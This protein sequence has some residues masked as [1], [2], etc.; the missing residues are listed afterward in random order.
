MNE[1]SDPSLDR[2][3]Y[4]VVPDVVDGES[5][6]EFD[7]QVSSVL[8][9]RAGARN[10]LSHDWCRHLALRLARHPAIADV[11]ASDAVAIS[12]TLFDKRAERN[13]S[14]GVHQDL[15]V[16]VARREDVPG[17]KGWTRKQGALFVQPPEDLLGRLLA[18]RVHLDECTADNGPLRVVP[19]THRLGRITEEDAL[20]L[21]DEIGEA[22]CVV[23]A[24]GALLMRPLLLHASGKAVSGRPRRVLHFVYGPPS[25]H[26][27]LSWPEDATS[28]AAFAEQSAALAD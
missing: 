13:W 2:S 9:Q 1:P 25:P 27:S 11:L 6:R 8:L 18:V 10:L 17:W 24:G 5:L 7:A 12:C 15:S 19:G 21:R 16:P 20:R 14:V 4:A 23:P 26:E 3:G 28:C 22:V